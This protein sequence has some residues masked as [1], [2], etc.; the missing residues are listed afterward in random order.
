MSRVG[1]MP[2]PIPP[3]VTVTVSGRTVEVAGPRGRL[4]REIHP[5][6]TVQVRDGAL[7]VQRPTD[8]ERHRALHGLTRALLANM[9]R[10]VVE[11]YRVELEIVGVGYRAVKQGDALSLQVGYSHPVV[12]RPPE[13]IQFDVPQPTRIVVSGLDKELVGQVAA[14]LR[15]I[16]PP[17]PYKGKGIRYVGER[18]R[19]KPGKA[20]RTVGGRA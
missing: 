16:R 17:D 13:G 8:Q 1:R 10:G 15:A 7:V 2:I 14:R 19:L 3:G 18:I 5:D 12:V 20:G 11:G 4:V 9:V 6:M